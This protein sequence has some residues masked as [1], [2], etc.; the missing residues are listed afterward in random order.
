M[1]AGLITQAEPLGRKKVSV[2][3]PDSWEKFLRSADTHF[4]QIEIQLF[5]LKE[6][7]FP[8]SDCA[9][10][11]VERVV[12]AT[13]WFIFNMRATDS[14][15]SWSAFPELQEK[16]VGFLRE[17]AELQHSTFGNVTND[18]MGDRT[19]L[20]TGIGRYMPECAEE[21]VDTLRSYSW[22]TVCSREIAARLGGA[23]RLR[24]TGAFYDVAELSYGGLLL[25]ATKE[26]G[27]YDAD[28]VRQVF[29]AL[30]CALPVGEAEMSIGA[31]Y[32]NLVY[33]VDPADVCRRRG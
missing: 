30:A 9:H 4:H 27:D 6:N 16:R 26:F 18:N 3:S 13:E 20:E 17:Q 8:G 24:E 10:I 33:G 29:D 7:G 28:R 1:W 22:T 32:W 12:G 14:L 2:Y 25:R 15:I 11:G 19:A 23:E 21:S 5:G 31:E